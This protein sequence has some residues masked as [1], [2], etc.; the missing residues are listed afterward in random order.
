MASIQFSKRAQSLQASVI[1]D[2][3]NQ[4]LAQPDI[5]SLAAGFTDNTML[6]RPVVRD[7]S[8]ALTEAGLSN[9]PLQYG[10]NQGRLALRELSCRQLAQFPNEAPEAFT[11]E[12]LFLSNGSQQALYLAMQTLCDPGS[13]VLVQDPTY[14]VFLELLQGLGIHAE[15]M[16]CDACGQIDFEA[17]TLR[18]QAMAESGGLVRLRAVYLVSYYAN[19]SS[20]S[21]GLAE[22]KQLARTLLA[23]G[24]QVPIIEDAAYRDLFFEEAHTAPSIFSLSEWSTFPKLYLGTYTKPFATGLKVGFAYCSES[25]WLQKMLITKGHH[26]FGSAHFNQALVESMLQAGAYAPHL[27][28]VRQHYAAKSARLCDALESGGLKAL[29]WDWEVPQ[30]GLILWLRAPVG[31]D[32]RMQSPFCTR[33]IEQ[34]V[35][36]VPGDLCFARANPWNCARLAFGA[37]SMEALSEAAARFCRVAHAF[38]A[39]ERS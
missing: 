18:L 29:G 20:H 26:D 21:M 39:C 16:P 19:P 25:E 37:L 17:L 10:Q 28:T 9:E 33:C 6:P 27:Q 15:A 2:L 31:M 4:A 13:I 3:M 7:M 8:T 1:V 14:F 12:Q 23:A 32:L 30:G 36:Y 34:G 11:A 24:I 38:A 35:L 22:K 5:L